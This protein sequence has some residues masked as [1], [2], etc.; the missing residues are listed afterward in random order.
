VPRR[1]V[2]AVLVEAY[3]GAVPSAFLSVDDPAWE[4]VDATAKW[5]TDHGLSLRHG[6][7]PM[8]L[9]WGPETRRLVAATAW[10]AASNA[11]LRDVGIPTNGGG[12]RRE[13][14]RALVVKFG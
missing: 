10:C 14:L 5:V 3:E 8:D 9:A 12:F 1:R 11:E 2:A 7:W 6:G 4:S 13:R